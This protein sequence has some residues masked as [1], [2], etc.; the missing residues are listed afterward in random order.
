M[1]A[2]TIKK[3]GT[4]RIAHF[5][6]YD[7][8]SLGDTMFPV[9]FRLEME[10]RFG[11]R[12][13]IDLYAP[14]GTSH[15]YNGLAQV[16]PIDDLAQRHAKDPY[17]A[18]VIGGGEF[19][20]F[21]QVS[22]QSPDGEE[23]QYRVGELWKK[24]QEIAAA[25]NIAVI[26]NAVG[27][28]R[29]FENDEE[30]EQIRQ[31][32]EGLSYLSV[33]DAYSR[34]RLQNAAVTR[35]IYQVP[36]MLWLFR[37][38]IQPETLDG[39]FLQLK[40]EYRFLSQD[41]L[42]LQYGTS[43]KYKKLAEEVQKISTD[44]GLAV[45]LLTVN[46]C[47][48]DQQVSY[49]IQDVCREFY[50]IGRK[51]QPKEIMSVISHAKFF[52]GTSLHGNITAMSYGIRNLC[53]DMYP[54][55][56]GKMDGLFAMMQMEELIVREISSLRVQ[57]DQQM[58]LEHSKIIAEKAAFFQ[59]E[60]KCHFDRIASLLQE[61]A[62]HR[63]KAAAGKIKKLEAQTES[64]R[65]KVTQA[66]KQCRFIKSVLNNGKVSIGCNS[67]M[68][69][70]HAGKGSQRL[71]LE[72][73][74]QQAEEIYQGKF[75]YP[76]PFLVE[77]IEADEN[78]KP[79]SCSLEGMVAGGSG[80]PAI[81]KDCCSFSIRVH[82]PCDTLPKVLVKVHV[83]LR[84]AWQEYMEALE[85]QA[86]SDARELLNR[87][88]HIELLLASE[89]KLTAE[90]QEKQEQVDELLKEEQ[91]LQQELEK[92]QECLDQSLK[93]EKTLK[94]ELKRKQECL[95]AY[96]QANQKQKRER[97]SRQEYL[98]ACAQAEQKLKQELLNK[99]GHIELLLETEREFERVKK[100]RTW[101]LA[102]GMQQCSARIVPP[103]SARRLFLKL[104]L[105]F[106]RH[107]MLFMKKLTP[108]R[109]RNFY[110]FFR[111]EGAEFVSKRV[112]L[113]MPEAAYEDKKPSVDLRLQKMDFSEYAPLVFPVVND[114]DVSIIIPVY[115]QFPYTY[116]CLKSILEQ[117]GSTVRYEIIIADDGSSDDTKRLSE[118][119]Q[120]IRIIR[121]PKNLL[122][123]RNC[124]HAS[125]FARGRYLLFLNNDT[126]V[127]ENWLEPL[128]SL[129]EHHPL[130]GM[131]GSKLIYPDG[132][133]QEA[134]GI[135]WND[136]SAWNYGNRQEADC[137]EYNYVKEVDYISG[138][139]LMIRKKLWQEIG[140]F[141]ERYAPAY[142][143]D[144][145]L[146]FEV[147]KHGYQV[148]YQPQSVVVHFEGISNGTDENRRKNKAVQ[149]KQNIKQYQMENSKKL[150]DKWSD[151][152][153]EH[154]PNAHHV[155]RARERSKGKPVILFIDHYIPQYDKDAGSRTIY[156]YM[157]MFIQKGFQVKFIGDNFYRNEPYASQLE[158]MGI[159]I[160]Y[161][162]YYQSHIF[163]WLDRNK[164]E[165]DFVFLNRPHISVKYIDFFYEKTNI[166]IIYYGLDLHFL[167]IRREY[168][169]T[170][171]NG[172]LREAK[173]WK[174]KE[175]YLMQRAEVSYY[176][177]PVEIEEIRRLD[178]A[179]HAKPMTIFVYEKFLETIQ[180]DFSK[181]EGILF[182]GGFVHEPNIDAVRWF[183]K[184]ILP[185][186][187]NKSD[188]TFYIVGS[189]ATKE[190]LVMNGKDG[191]CVK[192]FLSD[193]E[194]SKLY[195]GCRIAVIPLRY[196]AGV[197]GKV[198]EALYNGMPVITTS[199]GA[200]G[201]PGIEEVAEVLDRPD[202]FADETV[203]LYGD[204]D[205]L[206]EMAKK[207]QV[208]VKEHFSMESVWKSIENDFRI[209]KKE[210]RRMNKQNAKT[211]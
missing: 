99:Q 75:Y 31:A 118:L 161:G 22:Y 76:N 47:H 13:Q 74:V 190:I 140:G 12:L 72:Y 206:A 189:N 2:K 86:Q 100:S 107:P 11:D 26:W 120:N 170:G 77:S 180:L 186:I 54:S 204:L 81:Y 71:E 15:P 1:A 202:A 178:A 95:D 50:V 194:L 171:E 5:G 192:G 116:N 108:A 166:K 106:M 52:L 181:R 3:E 195:A 127:Q 154:Y 131:T 151:V 93:K 103:G 44:Y 80:A 73:Q 115:N 42:V 83:K 139:S 109:I 172:K 201:I 155:F 123:L 66:T 91:S 21:Q 198:I 175:M 205:R 167:R 138:A 196:G 145:D 200:E 164:A 63:Q 176:P 84:D 18:L 56:V 153:K 40:R 169:L 133:L 142:C 168:E 69:L 48:E 124:N 160:L 121:N 132:R 182:V 187:R 60:L 51:L 137:P 25:L 4:I 105:K 64:E 173:E 65:N 6:A 159:E 209:E 96:E 207:T 174:K 29:D 191:I 41:Y 143:E 162:S 49:K 35:S 113:S 148:V 101:R 20:H 45:L 144:S 117:T 185:R 88:G 16:Y 179:I 197:K 7:L 210:F 34:M 149:P 67:M 97:E 14:N 30:A 122:F 43:Y 59:E 119:V 141:D 208:Y 114:P 19:I 157:R 158:Q 203:R 46:C 152:L 27:A 58:H 165:I 112:E 79:V 184:E 37:R 70:S 68:E 78:G 163:Q 89:R 39:C 17:C 104:F 8:E 61:S 82:M 36:D 150:R 156:Q 53:L 85:G 130:V 92:K 38:H 125:T 134:G 28:G 102:F 55:C 147:R 32:C 126:Q 136:G 177:S 94:Y 90:S 57:F 110:H 193:E 199:I 183:T 33:R 128:V 129:L 87:Q 9:I 188:I 211:Q 62:E 146:A 10:E 135:I 111:E 98:K 24:P 23:R